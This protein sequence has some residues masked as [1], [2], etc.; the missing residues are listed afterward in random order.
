MALP[1][2]PET[3]QLVSRCLCISSALAFGRFAVLGWGLDTNEKCQVKL[4]SKRQRPNAYTQV[5]REGGV[6]HDRYLQWTM[7]L[8]IALHLNT[9]TSIHLCTKQDLQALWRRSPEPNEQL[10]K[11]AA[12]VM[13]KAYK[14]TNKQIDVCTS[15][16]IQ[17]K[18]F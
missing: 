1:P 12:A 3:F 4:N 17:H 9:A 10:T 14:Q 11:N 6:A 13:S 15:V 18:G 16:R 2:S 8:Q 7:T 5:G